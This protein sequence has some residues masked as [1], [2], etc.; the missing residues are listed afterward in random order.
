MAELHPDIAALA[1]LLG[2]WSG[3][4]VGDYPTIEPFEYLEDVAIGHTGK[5]FLTYTQRT[6]AEDGRPMHAETGYIRMPALGR[7]EFIVSHPTGVTEIDEGTLTDDGGALV[8]EV[9][10]TS[11]GLTVS[12]KAVAALQRWIRVADDELRYNLQ[13]GAVGQPLQQHLTATLYRQP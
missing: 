7:L 11:I 12:A 8:L 9:T 13:M 4:G 2:N 3:R 10:S 6:R 5:P 1:P